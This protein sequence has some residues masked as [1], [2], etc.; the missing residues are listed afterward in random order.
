MKKI[1]ILG[2][3]GSVGKNTLNVIRELNNYEIYALY[4]GSNISLLIE[5]AEE[6]NPKFV[7]TFFSENK[8]KLDKAVNGR[9]K[10]LYGVEG[11]NKL[12]EDE[13]VDIV[14]I[15]SAG[16]MTFDALI[17]AMEKGKRIATANKETIVSYSH[18]LR[19]KLTELP[20]ELI[21]VDSEHSAIYQSLLGAYRD[22]VKRI[23]L[24]ASGGPFYN[25]ES[26]DGITAEEALNH[27]TWNMGKKI[28]ID[29]AT[30]MNKALEVIEASVLFNLSP[31]KIE[32]VIHPESIIH[33]FVE[34]KDGSIISQL[35]LP[36]MKI[37]IQFALTA[38]E[39]KT[40]PAP[41][42]SISELGS[43]KFYKLDE[44]KF[45]LVPLAYHVLK[46]AGT[47]SAVFVSADEVAVDAFLSGKIE[48]KKIMDIVI[49]VTESHKVVE[50]PEK[51]DIIEAENWAREKAR[52]LIK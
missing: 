21:P 41:S 33:G 48:F 7:G 12:S 29:S 22:D 44:D 30:L 26:F 46:E 17:L 28:T 50:E 9:W 47:L 34:F 49:R 3:T 45:P 2:S 23:T 16:S 40:S 4:A 8:R 51:D 42:L 19:K 43:L 13:K 52:E 24:T 6:F 15:A 11:A 5:Q 35:S 39:H 32:V 20:G 1:A 31:D 10:T 36:D 14:V 25:R 27:P 18:L 37:P 38:P